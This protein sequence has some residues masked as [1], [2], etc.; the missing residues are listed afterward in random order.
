MAL[1]NREML[2][3]GQLETTKAFE[4]L[5]AIL[6]VEGIDAYAWGSNDLAQSMGFP[7][8][9]DHPEVKEAEW[10]VAERIHAAGREMSYDISTAVNAPSLIVEGARRFLAANQEVGPMHTLPANPNATVAA[11]RT[12]LERI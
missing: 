11:H 5:D 7:G 12:T 4:N 2:V 10:G 3:Q 6:A 8:Q 1:T 9:P